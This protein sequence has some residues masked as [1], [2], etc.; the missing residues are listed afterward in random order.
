MTDLP[1]H[2]LDW[3]GS[4]H[5]V[6]SPGAM[7][8]RESDG[9]GLEHRIPASVTFSTACAVAPGFRVTVAGCPHRLN[10]R[11]VITIRV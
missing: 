1:G 8:L 6:F 4:G 11:M 7:T 5:A 2:A 3:N 9:R 10:P